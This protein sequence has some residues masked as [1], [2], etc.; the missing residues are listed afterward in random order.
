MGFDGRVA[1]VARWSRRCPGAPDL[2]S[3]RFGT[4]GPFPAAGVRRTLWMRSIRADPRRTGSNLGRRPRAGR[5]DDP[6]AG[7]ARRHGG[8][9]PPVTSRITGHRPSGPDVQ[10]G[11]THHHRALMHPRTVSPGVQPLTGVRRS[12]PSGTG[13]SATPAGRADGSVG[14]RAGRARGRSRA[15]P[16]PARAPE[17]G[18]LRASRCT[19]ARMP[20][21][22]PAC[23]RGTCRSRPRRRARRPAP[24]PRGRRARRGGRTPAGRWAGRPAGPAE[25]G[26]GAAA[27]GRAAAA[28]CRAGSSSGSAAGPCHWYRRGPRTAAATGG[29]AG[30]GRRLRPGALGLRAAGERRIR[31][32]DLGHPARGALRDLRVVPREVRVMLT[33]E[34]APGDLD[35]VGRGVR[36]DAEHGSRV[37]GGHVPSVAKGS[38]LTVHRVHPVMSS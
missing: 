18:S 23:G 7:D 20:R 8:T 14:S 4:R 5:T 38:R 12:I 15:R 35:L 36:I 31:R 27:D 22:R 34:G 16:A 21:S 24:A 3:R 30:A 29:R 11:C 9:D 13:S 19:R 17:S 2:R 32:V 26:R 10:G 28:S 33:G 1:A 6:T 25:T 37:L